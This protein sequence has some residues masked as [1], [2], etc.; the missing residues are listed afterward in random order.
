MQ[1][2]IALILI[3]NDMFSEGAKLDLDNTFLNLEI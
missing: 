2:L 3:Y 1:Q